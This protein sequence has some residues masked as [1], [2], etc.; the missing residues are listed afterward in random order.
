MRAA[1]FAQGCGTRLFDDFTELKPGSLQKLQDRLQRASQDEESAG[2][3]DQSNINPTSGW[4]VRY[5]FRWICQKVTGK[6]LDRGSDP[7]PSLE[8]VTARP[9]TIPLEQL[10]ILRLLFCIHTGETGMKLYQERLSRIDSD[11]DLL[12]FLRSEYRRRR[13][14]SSWLT[15]RGIT[16]VS[17]ARVCVSKHWC[18]DQWF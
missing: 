7:L 18:Y 16:G 12:L 1:N 8:S 5:I 3:P 2:V 11:C 4:N 10:N 17:L 14:I 9:P 6:I 13:K 15:F